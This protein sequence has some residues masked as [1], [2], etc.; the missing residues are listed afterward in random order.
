MWLFQVIEAKEGLSDEGF[1]LVS[2]KLSGDALFQTGSLILNAQGMD[3]WVICECCLMKV[4]P[5]LAGS[6]FVDGSAKTTR[7]PGLTQGSKVTFTCEEVTNDR[8]R[9]HIDS[10]NKTVT[11]DWRVPA[12]TLYFALCWGQV[13]WKV[14]VE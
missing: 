3:I 12:Q 1:G 10:D 13:G 7:L 9:V 14:L 4:S 11:Y 8:V 5:Y 2:K 6:V